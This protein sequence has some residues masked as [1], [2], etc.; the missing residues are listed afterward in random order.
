MAL[1]VRRKTRTASA[2]VPIDHASSLRVYATSSRRYTGIVRTRATSTEVSIVRRPAHNFPAN[3]QKEGHG[4]P[5]RLISRLGSCGGWGPWGP[6]E[7]EGQS[8]VHV[9]V[10]DRGAGSI[11]TSTSVRD[12]RAAA[13]RRRGAWK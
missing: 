12:A 2:T 8:L 13:G 5:Q 3:R 1:P 11:R 4:F 10:R 9:P 6:H 7:L